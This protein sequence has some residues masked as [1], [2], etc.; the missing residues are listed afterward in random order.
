MKKQRKSGVKTREKLLRAAS[1]VF[2]D[3]NYRDATIDEI[4]EKAQANIAAVNYHFND[5]ETLY[6]EAWRYAF[7]GSIKA[8][9]PDGG[10]RDND[11]P[12][13][14]LRGQITALLRRIADENNKE[15]LIAQKEFVSPTGLLDEVIREELEPMHD[16]T[17]AVVRELLGRK[18]SDMDVQFCA[19]SIINQC[20]NPIVAKRKRISEMGKMVEGPPGIDDIDA[21]ADHVARFSLAGIAEI[22]AKRSKKSK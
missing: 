10:V 20:A 18:V 5:K 9:P 7:A 2:A 1:E 13:K 17:E 4:C 12:E 16:R 14:C 21:Y 22:R 11:T 15:F 19:I 6:R 8:Y 3:K